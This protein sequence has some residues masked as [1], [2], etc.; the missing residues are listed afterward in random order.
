MK[1][2]LYCLKIAFYF[3]REFCLIVLCNM[4]LETH[5]NQSQVAAKLQNW[6]FESLLT[7]VYVILNAGRVLQSGIHILHNIIQKSPHS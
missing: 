4:S 3:T 1:S 7:T 2:Q 5:F 6:T